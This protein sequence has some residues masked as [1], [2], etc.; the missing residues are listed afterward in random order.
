MR[1][2]RLKKEEKNWEEKYNRF[3][4]GDKKFNLELIAKSKSPHKFKLQFEIT[5]PKQKKG[6]PQSSP[7]PAK[8]EVK[9]YMERTKLG[10]KKVKIV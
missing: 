6:G 10:L 4:K 5:R 3:Y 8:L 7:R 1:K 2:E 9:E